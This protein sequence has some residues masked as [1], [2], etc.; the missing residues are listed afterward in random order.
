M[1]LFIAASNGSDGRISRVAP[2]VTNLSEASRPAYCS[3]PCEPGG[4][5]FFGF[6]AC[7]FEFCACAVVCQDTAAVAPHNSSAQPALIKNRLDRVNI[8]LIYFLFSNR[9]LLI[10]TRPNS[11]RVLPSANLMPL[12]QFRLLGL[13]AGR[14]RTKLQMKICGAFVS[15]FLS[16]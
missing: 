13:L 12:I 1:P 10:A 2:P 9:S 3:K 11:A 7:A 8:F 16:A 14:G 5:F 4:S 6:C 15:H